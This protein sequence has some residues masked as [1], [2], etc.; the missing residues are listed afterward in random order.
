MKN[1]NLPYKNNRISILF[2]FLFLT[3]Q[4]Q[5]ETQAGKVKDVTWSNKAEIYST[6]TSNYFL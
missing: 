3:E 1:G 2:P 5:R 6:H 4:S